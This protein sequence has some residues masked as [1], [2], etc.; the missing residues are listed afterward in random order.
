[1]S[2]QTSLSFSLTRRAL[3]CSQLHQ[4]MYTVSHLLLCLIDGAMLQSVSEMQSGCHT[5]TRL[6]HLGCKG[7]LF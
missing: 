7:G 3:I 4:D 1:M 5:S 6:L 2:F